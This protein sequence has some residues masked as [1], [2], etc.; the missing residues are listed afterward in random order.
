MYTDNLCYV[1]ILVHILVQS[2]KTCMVG[3]SLFSAR[4][5]QY[6]RPSSIPSY[7]PSESELQKAPTTTATA[8]AAAAPSRLAADFQP[9]RTIGRVFVL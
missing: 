6:N 2:Y 5:Q 7:F 9:Y 1:H 3:Q 4:V 8:V